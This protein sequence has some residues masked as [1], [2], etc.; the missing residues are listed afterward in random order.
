VLGSSVIA[1]IAALTARET[2]RRRLEDIDGRP[3]R[4]VREEEP[5][6]ATAAP[7]AH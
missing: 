5:V 7:S 3:G 4:F 1:A 6:L 2:S